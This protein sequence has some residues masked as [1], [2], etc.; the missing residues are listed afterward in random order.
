MAFINLFIK[1]RKCSILT[2]IVQI[3]WKMNFLTFPQTFLMC[4][5]SMSGRVPRYTFGFGFNDFSCAEFMVMIR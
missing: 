2:S 5:V 1:V 3:V 4:N